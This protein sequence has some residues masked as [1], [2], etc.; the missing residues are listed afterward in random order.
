MYPPPLV[1]S[2][3]PLLAKQ[4]EFFYWGKK[5]KKPTL[6]H[7]S[8]NSAFCPYLSALLSTLPIL[9]DPASAGG[10]D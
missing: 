4:G 9:G 1:A 2:S 6:G 10:L 3:F 8:L 7:S 5:K